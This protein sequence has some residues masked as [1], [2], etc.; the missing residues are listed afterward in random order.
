MLGGWH[1]LWRWAEI[2]SGQGNQCGADKY[3]QELPTFNAL[4]RKCTSELLKF[5]HLS[6]CKECC[7]AL[8]TGKDKFRLNMMCLDGTLH[9]WKFC[10]KSRR[11]NVSL[12]FHREFES[13]KFFSWGRKKSSN[14]EKNPWIWNQTEY[15]RS[16]LE[17][18]FSRV[19][20]RFLFSLFP[21]TQT[22]LARKSHP[23]HTQRVHC[24]ATWV[25]I[26]SAQKPQP[27]VLKLF[28]FDVTLG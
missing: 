14:W 23:L 20:R 10:P 25:F 2:A 28:A 17:K 7:G 4:R 15:K 26:R 24:P 3:E 22:F 6:H 18:V 9:S 5:S 1:I 16:K 27:K 21:C 19:F 13:W 11:A 8:E 12:A